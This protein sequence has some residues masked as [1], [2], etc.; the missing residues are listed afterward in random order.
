MASYVQ[1]EVQYAFYHIAWL[2][3]MVLAWRKDVSQRDRKSLMSSDEN[4]KLQL[5]A[6][7]VNHLNCFYDL[8]LNLLEH[9]GFWCNHLSSFWS[10]TARIWYCFWWV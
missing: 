3:L 1:K 4:V 2:W 10:A 6:M 5:F 8:D 7:W 9:Q